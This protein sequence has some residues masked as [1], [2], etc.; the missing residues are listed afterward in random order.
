[1]KK[2][3]AA[4]IGFLVGLL[5]FSVGREIAF[6]ERSW[7]Q[8]LSDALRTVGR[9]G[10]IDTTLVTG[11]AAVIAAWLSVGAVRQQINQADIFEKNRIDAKHTAIRAAIPLALSDLIEYCEETLKALETTHM[12]CVSGILPNGAV[13]PQFQ[14]PPKNAVGDLKEL[15]EFS[16]PE[17][18]RFIWQ[19]LVSFQILQ[20]RLS[21]LR[22]SHAS[23]TSIV[24]EL[25][26]EAYIVNAADLMARVSAY[27]NY[28]RGFAKV[29]PK[30]VTRSEV[31]GAMSAVI[32]HVSLSGVISRFGLTGDEPWDPW[33]RDL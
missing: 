15:I 2:S 18:R 6:D 12:L 16:K 33:T 32:W 14:M 31:A 3:V 24:S 22:Q 1:M 20:A 11:F 21:G 4:A 29:P 17:D 8:M 5:L 9:L 13:L 19:V 26:I 7:A 27:F 10:W 28:A 30:M 23:S 25:N